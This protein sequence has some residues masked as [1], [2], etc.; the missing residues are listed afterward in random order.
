MK[1]LL[2]I[3]VLAAAAGCSTQKRSYFAPTRT[4]AERV[5][6][7]PKSPG[8]VPVETRQFVP[9]EHVSS[10]LRLACEARAIEDEIVE[11]QRV[12]S[13]G[14]RIWIA[15]TS[16]DTLEMRPTEFRM[17]DELGRSYTPNETLFDGEP[18]G[19]VLATPPMRTRVDV[20]FRLPAG[21]DPSAMRAI[22]FVWGFR[23]KDKEYREE[24]LLERAPDRE[25]RDPFLPLPP[26]S[27]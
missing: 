27:S 25:L 14:I 3:A 17:I 22:K 23:I 13:L 24:T 21:R 19:V 16:K 5:Y 6:T 2:V 11:G 9:V 10:D 15:N 20:V 12:G 4:S 26:R 7:S 8:P 18:A 1:A